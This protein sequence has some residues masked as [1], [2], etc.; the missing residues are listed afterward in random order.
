M[1]DSW[2]TQADRDAK[3]DVSERD[4]RRRDVLRAGGAAA[5]VGLLGTA[6]AGTAAAS[7]EDTH[8]FLFQNAWMLNGIFGN[9]TDIAKPEIG[10]RAAGFGQ[11]LQG[12]DLDIVAFCEVFA[13]DQREAIRAPIERDLDWEIGPPA[14]WEKSSGLY[15]LGIGGHP[16]TAMERYEFENDGYEP[17]DADAWA[18][19]GVLFTRIAVDGGEVDVFSTHLLAGGGIPYTDWNP[20]SDPPTA[21]EYRAAQL[22]EAE[23]FVSAVKDAY[24][25]DREVPTIFAGDFNISPD[26]GEYGNLTAMRD[27]LGLYD[28]WERHGS[29]EGATNRDA[30]TG[31]C[32]FDS[33]QSLPSYCDGGGGGGE[34]I[35]YVFLDDAGRLEVE[36]IRRRVFWRQRAPP[37]QFYVNGDEEETNYLTDHIGL[38]LEFSLS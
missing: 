29:G 21:E 36:D 17:R 20:F 5:S 16:I 9:D 14:E 19:K 24:D 6:G 8:R 37:D 11:R 10:E 30:I 12:S 26:S 34:R 31:G 32:A 28:A 25:P 38:E 7:D 22:A 15:T 33:A 4:V 35:D 18:K 1:T 13:S 3:R 23:A 2:G 27:A